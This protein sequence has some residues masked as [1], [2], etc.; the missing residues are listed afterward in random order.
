[1][2]IGPPWKNIKVTCKSPPP[3]LLAKL[4]ASCHDKQH[5]H[6]FAWKTYF[7]ITR[8]ISVTIWGNLPFSVLDHWPAPLLCSTLHSCRMFV[9][10]CLSWSGWVERQRCLGGGELE[11]CIQFSSNGPSLAQTLVEEDV[12]TGAKLSL[13]PSLAPQWPPMWPQWEA[14]GVG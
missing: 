8:K 13:I 3:F 10:S 2:G 12:Y 7:Q 6:D 9:D 11:V 5:C 4:R 14:N 1:M